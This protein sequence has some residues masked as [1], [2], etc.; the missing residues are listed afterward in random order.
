V[1][2]IA[3]MNGTLVQNAEYPTAD[4]DEG[5]GVVDGSDVSCEV[6]SGAAAFGADD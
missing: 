5:A 2:I 1:A 6:V 3:S 4:R